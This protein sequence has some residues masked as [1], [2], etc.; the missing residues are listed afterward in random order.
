MIIERQL[1]FKANF[2]SRNKFENFERDRRAK[3]IKS[4]MEVQESF[5][6]DAGI[7]FHIAYQKAL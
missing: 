7:P 5:P 2:R 1:Q 4:P 6:L 3:V